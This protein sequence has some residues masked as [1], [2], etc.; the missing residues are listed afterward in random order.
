MMTAAAGD[1]AHARSP[2]RIEDAALLTGSARFVDDLGEPP[3]CLHLAILRSSE[4]HARIMRLDLDAA[5]ALPGVAA[6][7]SGADVA[8][9]TRP[10]MVGVRLPMEC[11]PIAQDRVRYVGEPVALV[12]AASRYVAEDALDLIEVAYEALPPIVDPVDALED[13][14]LLHE[15][16]GTNLVSDRR[17]T[18]GDPAAAFAAADRTVRV[19]IRYPRNAVT[20]IE[21]YGLIAA[22]DPHEDAFDVTANFQGPFSIHSVLSRAL[23]VPGNRLRLR[24]PPSSGGSFGVKQGIFPYI[25]LAGVAARVAGRSVKWIEDRLEHL[26]ASVSATNR[27]TALQAAVTGDGRI[28]ALDWDQLEDVGAYMRAPEPATIYRMH[29]NM[30]GAYDIRNVVIRNRVVVTNKTPTGL[31]RGFGG[32]QVYFALERLIQRIAL[33]LGMDPL[34]VIRRN[35]IAADAFPYRTAMG[36]LYDSG[37]Y[38]AALALG[39]DK[40]AHGDLLARR[41]A[42]RAEG[43]LYGIGY[44]VVVEPSVSNM[45]YV[46][47][48]LTAEQRAKSGPKN[49]AQSTATVAVDPVGGVSVHVAS[50]PQGQGH[51]TVL[52]QV[53]GDVLGLD[54]ADVTVN[55]D[56]DT[57]RDAWSIASGNYSSRF[58]AAVAGAGKLAAERMRDKLAALVAGSLNVPVEEVEFAGGTIR[59]RG[60]PDNALPFVRAAAT[61]HW[62][63]ATVPEGAGQALRETVFWTPPQLEAPDAQDRVNSSLC[64]GFIFDFCGVEVE[65]STGQVRIDRYVTTH[66]CGT[67]LHQGMVDGQIRGGYANAVGAALYEEYAYSPGGNFLA[68][69]FADYL[70]PTAAEVPPIEIFHMETPSPFT[71]LGAKGV[72]EGNCMSTP[73]ALANAVSDAIGRPVDTLPMT[74]ARLRNLI[75]DDEPAAP[76]GIEAVPAETTG[77]RNLTGQGEVRIDARRETV[78]DILLDPETLRRIVPGCHRVEKLAETHFRAEVTLGVGPVKG[79]YEVDMILADLVPPASASLSGSA[80]GALG[81]GNGQGEISLEDLGESRTLLR[82]SYEASVGGKVAAVGGRMLDGAARVVIGQFFRALAA[83]TGAARPGLKERIVRL[84]RRS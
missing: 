2:E 72:G 44:A 45:G 59:A 29:G 84:W 4:A 55:T 51:R 26:T 52:A 16:V 7:L 64:H 36:A 58:A 49:G 43:R 83:H 80:K 71:P 38:Q 79:R 67:I 42:A 20:P 57:G 69:T 33:E 63:P 21:C 76:A 6:V 30:T 39:L 17:F 5:R 81:S 15:A 40:G 65:R 73:A 56:L 41:D 1:E 18:Y 8:R 28:T 13:A 66:D 34:D 19:D 60:N 11:W 75:A 68:G 9:L 54:A 31:V 61:S 25:V 24:T 62:A 74:P 12:V 32:P 78:W 47:T 22:Y 3:G 53:V 35:L 70:V 46:S 48:V 10:L 77:G 37:D 27:V 82:Y 23:K 50:V 14:T